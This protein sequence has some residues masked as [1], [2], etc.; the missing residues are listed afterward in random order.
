MRVGSRTKLLK[1]G[2]NYYGVLSPANSGNEKQ[3]KTF[4]EDNGNLKYALDETTFKDVV[5]AE[6]QQQIETNKTDI[7]T[8]KT[9]VEELGN[10]QNQL[11]NDLTNEISARENADN[12]L[13][14][15]INGII[16]KIY[17]IG[18]IYISTNTTNPSEYLGG[19]W[20]Q[21][22]D[23]FLLASGDIYPNGSRGGEA[24]HTLTTNE[25]PSHTHIQNA[26][27]HSQEPHRHTI[28]T[29][30]GDK[31]YG[32]TPNGNVYWGDNI[33]REH[34]STFE[35]AVNDPTTATNQNTGGGQPHNN[36]PPYYAVTI[37]QR[38]G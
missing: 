20:A 9:D 33:A 38:M 36:M 10:E 17:P 24:T 12:V 3:V 28:Y 34:I 30:R 25:M 29:A 15:Q 13:R 37:W 7:A 5:P 19:V 22:K 35:N 31:N 21:I 23:T 11:A 18:S 8:L 2:R 6:T 32:G 4:V 14:A 26:H 27:N 16:D 1:A